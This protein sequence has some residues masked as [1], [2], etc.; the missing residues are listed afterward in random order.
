M[1]DQV[2]N[3]QV[4]LD[5]DEVAEAHDP[6]NAE[7]D[8]AKV[9]DKG[10]QVTKQAPGRKGDKRSSEPM[11]KVKTKGAMLSAIYSKLAAGSTADIST[12]YKNMFGED[13]DL[14]DENLTE[15]EQASYDYKEELDSIV[16]EEATLSEEFKEKTT[17]IFEAALNSKIASEIDRLEEEY[18][19]TLSEELES[20]QAELVE[21]IDGYLNYV[22]ENWMEE[23]KLAV[24]NGLRTEI[25]EN[26]MD[27][28]KTLFV[29]SYVEVPESKVDLVDELASQVEELEEKLNITTLD[30]ISLMEENEKYARAIIIAEASKDLAETE[31]AKLSK[32]VE[33]VDFDN[34]EQFEK[35]VEVIKESYFSNKSTNSTITEET[36]D[37]DEVEE[38]EVSPQMSA[39]VNTLK[40]IKK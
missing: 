2:K 25:A 1:T 17:I 13:V 12:A 23:N 32:L 15:E 36:G 35:A 31:K 27:G 19:N 7:E 40:R 34:P 8:A 26:F 30:A 10:T 38:T 3:D 24:Q 39:Y 20:I 9:V 18:A 5:E 22:V 11:Q 28:L 16:N 29:E 33:N 21:K 4:E 14:D 6:K 37:A